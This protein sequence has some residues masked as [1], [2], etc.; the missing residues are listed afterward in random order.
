MPPPALPGPPGWRVHQC[1]RCVCSVV[2]RRHV[3]RKQPNQPSAVI[4]SSLVTATE[5]FVH[6]CGFIFSGAVLLSAVSVFIRGGFLRVQCG[7]VIRAPV[8]LQSRNLWPDVIQRN[9]DVVIG[10]LVVG[11]LVIQLSHD[12]FIRSAV[13][14]QLRSVQRGL[15]RL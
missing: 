10:Q 8:L 14:Q 6:G 2:K 15:R 12:V 1:I 9:R 11:Q 13:I 5:F 4:G 3:S 7:S